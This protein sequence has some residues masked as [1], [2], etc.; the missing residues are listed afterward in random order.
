MEERSIM[1]YT[2]NEKNI[3]SATFNDLLE[4]GE[5]EA[6]IQIPRW[7]CSGL[8]TLTEYRITV[9]KTTKTIN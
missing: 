2:D 9:K 4:E 8:E 6:I 3:L 5:K 1:Q 7:N